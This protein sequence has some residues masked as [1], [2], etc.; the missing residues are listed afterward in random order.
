MDNSRFRF[1]PKSVTHH[2]PMAKNIPSV[3]G[4]LGGGQLAKMLA[5]AAYPLGFAVKVLQRRAD[6][7]GMA[8]Q[9]T[10]GD[11]DDPKTLV[12][13]ARTV[14]VVT[15][16]NEFVDADALSAMEADG[17]PLWPS[18]SCIRLVQDKLWQ[19]QTLTSAG[20]SVPDFIDAPAPERLLAAARSWGWPLVLK[21]RRNG[22]DGKGNATVR[23]EDD[24]LPAWERLG[25]DHCPLYVERFCPF[26]RELAVMVVRSQGGD[27]VVYPVVETI[28]KDHICHEVRV[29]AYGHEH[30]LDRIAE[31]ARLAVEAIGGVGAVG[32][33]FF[34]LPNGAVVVNEMAPRV[35]NSGHYSIEACECSQFENHIRAIA[36]LPL[37]SPALRKPAAVMINLLGASDGIGSPRGMDEAL[38]IRGVHIHCYGKDRSLRGRKMGHLTTLGDSV[39]SA[40]ER[41]RQAASLI[42]FGSCG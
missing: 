40:L 22:Y 18:A 11:W 31:M 34:E 29:P 19:K 28:Q 42:R 8:W 38:A 25:G 14:D 7:S 1:A 32:I 24:V 21:K 3:L 36:G 23:S 4:I 26:V 16:E 9:T 33:E 39:D 41:A 27:T 15:L 17:H 2:F 20:I 6:D 10:I 13:F 35:H 5:L 30:T 37:G 12:T